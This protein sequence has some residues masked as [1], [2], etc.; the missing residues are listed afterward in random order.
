[1]AKESVLTPAEKAS[2]TIDHFIFHII[3]AGE[4]NPTTLAEVV[5]T[6]EQRSFF[7]ERLAQAAEGTQYL[8]TDPHASTPARCARILENPDEHFLGESIGLAQDFLNQHRRNMSNGVFVV[9]VVH[10]D[11]E[12][13]R[14]PLISLIKMDHTRVLEYLTERTEGGLVAKLQEVLNT[15]V[16]D[17]SAL[18]KVALIDAGEYYAWDVLAKERRSSEAITDY[19]KGF[20]S[21]K[22]R[23]DPS[24]W[25]RQAISAVTSWALENKAELPDDQDPSS[26]KARAISYMETHGEFGTDGFLDMVVL[27]DDPDRR[28]VLRDGLYDRL[29]EKGVAGQTFVPKPGS[30]KKSVRRNRYVTHEG[31]TVEWEGDA[32]TVGVTVESAGEGR[33]RIVIETHGFTERN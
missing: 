30:I 32:R 22:E 17:K 12:N 3:I 27:D 11:R 6:D 31:V 24:H 25:T 20:L 26:F 2:I 21:V 14:I 10:L 23:E 9:A 19:F 1:M 33:Q 8:F 7:R 28:Q 18:Q 5:L 29:A 13:E 15:F 4:E 16:E